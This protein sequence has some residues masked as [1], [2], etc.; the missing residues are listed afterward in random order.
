MPD[1]IRKVPDKISEDTENKQE[2]AVTDEE[3]T[4]AAGGGAF[5]FHPIPLMTP[6]KRMEMK[7]ITKR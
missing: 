1:E 6:P 5:G 3:A 7:K 2:G 4:D